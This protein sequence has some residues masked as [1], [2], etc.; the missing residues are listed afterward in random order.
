M[1]I[2]LIQI[3]SSKRFFSGQDSTSQSSMRFPPRITHLQ[4]IGISFRMSRCAHVKH[5]RELLVHE[6]LVYQVE[7]QPFFNGIMD[8]MLMRLPIVVFTSIQ[9]WPCLTIHPRSIPVDSTPILL[10]FLQ[11]GPGHYD[12][13]VENKTDLASTPS[14][15]TTTS[16]KKIVVCR[17]GRGRNVKNKQKINCSKSSTSRCPCLRSSKGCT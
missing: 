15:T 8:A 17:C 2:W 1:L 6:W 7:Y 5:L 3:S 10:S 13:L 4:N 16:Q 12:L 14:S 9:S 11:V